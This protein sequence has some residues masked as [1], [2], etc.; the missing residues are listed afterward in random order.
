MAYWCYDRDNCHSPSQW[1]IDRFR[2]ALAACM[3]ARWVLAR[4]L[5]EPWLAS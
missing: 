3:K 2:D 4:Q 5:A 1:E